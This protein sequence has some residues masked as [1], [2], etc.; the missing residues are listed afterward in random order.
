MPPKSKQI[1][2]T[3]SHVEPHQAS[4]DSSDDEPFP[5]DDLE[6]LESLHVGKGSSTGKE[7]RQFWMVQLR[8]G[9]GEV[10]KQPMRVRDLYELQNGDK[11]IIPFDGRQPSGT[12]ADGLLGGYLGRLAADHRCFPISFKKWPDVPKTYK[13]DVWKTIKATLWWD[14]AHDDDAK[15]YMMKDM[16]KKWREYRLRLYSSYYDP[17][18]SREEHISNPPLSIPTTEWAS[19]LDYRS[20]EGTKA[21][22]KKYAQNRSKLT[23][24]HTGGSKKLK[25]KRVEIMAE[26]GQLVSRGT[27]Y[28]HTHK[29]SDGTYINEEAQAVCEKISEIESQG[30]APVAIST[31]DSLGQVFGKEHSGCVR[32]VGDGVC[33]TQVFGSS[34]LRFNA[35]SSSSVVLAHLLT[36]PSM[37]VPPELVNGLNDIQI[38]GGHSSSQSDTNQQ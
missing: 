26:T 8:S 6:E 1:Q 7:K 33:P 37:P 20:A 4:H 31:N 9:A 29:R 14:P 28:I 19:L 16:G 13:D 2:S 30:T 21:I 32:G 22:C 25:R 11:V 35:A 27:L 15:T 36:N 10:R 5:P 18:K 3:S 12:E 17:T 23:I 38:A 34:N 24:N